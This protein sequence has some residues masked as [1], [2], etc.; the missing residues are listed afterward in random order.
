M[1]SIDRIRMEKQ[2]HPGISALSPFD[3]VCEYAGKPRADF[4][5]DSHSALQVCI[6]LHGEAEMMLEGFSGKYREGELWWNMCWEPHAYRLSGRNNFVMAINLDVEHLGACSPFGSCNW[7]APFVAKPRKRYLPSTQEERDFVRETGKR[8]FHAC[9]KKTP[10]CQILCWLLIHELLIYAINHMD[11]DELSGE[12]E[13][14]LGSFLRI[15][16]ALNEVWVADARPPNLSDAA[17][18]CGLSSSRFSEL[19]RRTM[20]S[21]YG[22][23]AIRIRM[24]NAANDLLS[25]NY[26]LE[27]IS[28]K[29]G[30]FDS[31]HFC[32]AFKKFYRISPSQFVSRKNNA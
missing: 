1:E 21:S 28:L 10:N 23:F 14:S 2:T 16:K 20:G 9:R 26:S 17:K 12:L 18:M 30:F 19:F 15:R 24:S 6:V 5:G 7:L 27:E 25:G 11:W 31:S 29:W 3:I 4:Q 32:H 13:E 22:K 8:I